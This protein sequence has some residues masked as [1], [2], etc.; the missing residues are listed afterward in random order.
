MEP[1]PQDRPDEIY[2]ARRVRPRRHIRRRPKSLLLVIVVGVVIL[3]PAAWLYHVSRTSHPVDAPRSAKSAERLALVAAVNK[4]VSQTGKDV[5]PADL[6][7]GSATLHERDGK[8]YLLGAIQNHGERA[9]SRVHIIFDTFDRSRNPAGLVEGD[10]SGLQPQKD[11]RFEIGPV[12]PGVRTFSVRSI[13][14]VQ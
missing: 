4:I 8:F 14:P 3:L 13:R 5:P 10:V 2:R 7:V 12:N 1:P 9:Y 6:V 11:G